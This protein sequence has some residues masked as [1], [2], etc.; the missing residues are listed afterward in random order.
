VAP[1]SVDFPR[2][3]FA[4]EGRLVGNSAIEALG[5]ESAE[6]GF[7]HIEPASVLWRVMRFE[8]FD[9]PSRLLGRKGVAKINVGYRL[10]YVGVVS[11]RMMVGDLDVTPA[12]ERREYHE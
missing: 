8:A 3:H 10:E 11:G 6:F 5:R 2:G 1:I 9:E 12:F 4:G 7:G